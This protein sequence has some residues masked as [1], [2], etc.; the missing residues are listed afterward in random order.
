HL[1]EAAFLAAGAMLVTRCITASK[2]RR[3][4]DLPVL[5]VIAASFSLGN[6]MTLTG[7][8]AGIA[9][10]LIV[11]DQMDPWVALALVYLMTVAFT[12][13]ITN[14]AAAVLMFPIA[15]AVSEQLGVSYLPFVIVTMFAAS[16]SFITPLGYQTN[17]MVYGP[18][19]YK[20]WDY[21][22]LGVP[23][24][25]ISGVVVVLVV[26]FVWVF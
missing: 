8:A 24:S 6:A 21:V 17:M 11:S 26:P 7:A 5:V 10:L 14:N 9:E 3:Y 2:A 25:L 16:A 18:G 20:L 1:M 22:K 12:E 4:I 15:M 23:L 13:V 19:R